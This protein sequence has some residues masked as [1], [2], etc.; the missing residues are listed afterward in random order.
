MKKKEQ[1]EALI[2]LGHPPTPFKGGGVVQLAFTK[3]IATER[4]V[5]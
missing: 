2:L 1:S 4:M 5:F 3:W